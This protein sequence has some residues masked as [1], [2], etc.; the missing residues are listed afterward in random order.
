MKLRIVL[1]KVHIRKF[2][3][4]KKKTQLK[5]VISR[6]TSPQQPD[7]NGHTTT[8]TGGQSYRCF[9][10][11]GLFPRSQMEWV[12]TSAEGVNSHAM[13]FPC[14]ARVARTSE[15][16]CMDSHGRV[17]SCA[18][19]VDHLTKQWEALEAERV[20]LERRRGIPTPPS[21]NSDRTVCSNSNP[22]S[23]GSSIYCF[24]CGFHSELTLARVVY[25]KPQETKW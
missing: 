11:S 18:R 21:T 13:H 15:N 3:R 23:G 9:I 17:L 1:K 4:T 24:L 25:S 6:P 2:V 7:Q 20:P 10:C 22:G 8:S 19:C 16:S 14:L 5:Q 12:S